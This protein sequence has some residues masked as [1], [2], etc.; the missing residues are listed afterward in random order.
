MRFRHQ[1]CSIELYF[2]NDEADVLGKVYSVVARRKGRIVAEEMR[3]GT[4]YFSVQAVIPAYESFGFADDIRKRTSGAASPQL[5]FA[6]FEILSQDPFWVP[7][8]TE[9]LEDLGEVSDRENLALKH[10]NDI[11]RRKVHFLHSQRLTS[12]GT[13]WPKADCTRRR[14]ATDAEKISI[15]SKPFCSPQLQC[16]CQLNMR[17]T[18]YFIIRRCVSDH[19]RALLFSS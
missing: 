16:L 17:I 9:E 6:G 7:S 1:V 18:N 15:Y 8:T 5:I 19:T 12:I 14:E 13:C 2:V 4:P 10:V 3:E 11:R